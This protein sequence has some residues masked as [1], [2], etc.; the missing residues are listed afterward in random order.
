MPELLL[1][2]VDE[3]SGS[4]LVDTS[5]STI[6]QAVQADLAE[7][8]GDATATACARP[9]AGIFLPIDVCPDEHDGPHFIPCD[10]CE[11]DC[12]LGTTI[13]VSA[14][15]HESA[16]E[17]PGRR[18]VV[19]MQGCP[20]R[21]QGCYV[22]ETWNDKTGAVLPVTTIANALLL[23]PLHQHGDGVAILG[24]PFAQPEALA[25]LVRELRQRQP[26]L[27]VLVYSGFTLEALRYMAIVHPDVGYV[28]ETVDMLIDGPYIEALADGAGPW[29]GS[30][31]QRVLQ[32][33]NVDGQSAWVPWNG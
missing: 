26:D 24:E 28:L 23:E 9:S 10:G 8:L 32:R 4:L 6:G 27:H 21:C 15:W 29:T 22:P 16:I 5:N 19:R 31:N 30:G 11:A 25:A 2:V 3:R 14:M 18:S 1:A 33:V 12:H 13:S 20:I 7:Q 17:G